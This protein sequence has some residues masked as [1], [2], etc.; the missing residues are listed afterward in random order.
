MLNLFY[1][2]TLLVLRT[3]NTDIYL[4]FRIFDAILNYLEYL[5]KKIEVYAYSSRD[6]ILKTCN[7]ASSKLAKY[8]SRTELVVKIN[9]DIEVKILENA[10]SLAL[11]TFLLLYK[12]LLRSIISH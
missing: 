11:N 6:I 3:I 1:E 9:V 4:G 10:C 7:K 8:Y 12:L 5:K 2:T